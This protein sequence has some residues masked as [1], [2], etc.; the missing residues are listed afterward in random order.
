MLGNL[1]GFLQAS[2]AAALLVGCAACPALAAPTLGWKLIASYPHSTT[3]FTEGLAICNGN[4]VES[5]GLYGNSQIEIRTLHTGR[6]LE[7]HTLPA[8]T[9]G[10]G[11]T[12]AGGRI[13]QLTW[14]AGLVF[15]YDANLNPLGRYPLDDEG[16][17]LA[18]DGQRL[19]ASDGTAV[20]HF[21]DP[22]SLEVTGSVTVRD[23]GRPVAQLNELEYALGSVWANVWHTDRIARIAENSGVVTG[24]LDLSK[25]VHR[26]HRNPRWVPGAENVL[27]GIAYDADSGHFFVTGKDWPEMYEIALD[28]GPARN[29]AVDSTSRETVDE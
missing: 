10:E 23:D 16:W 27:N 20:L 3:A 24:W 4:L 1:K 12:C 17:G 22:Q 5:D 29:R 13:L 8:N 7:H 18:F 26:V 15:A 19:I 21:L 14:R 28:H 2:L 9:F 25:L 11:T 6:V